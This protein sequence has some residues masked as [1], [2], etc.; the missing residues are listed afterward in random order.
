MIWQCLPEVALKNESNF[1]STWLCATTINNCL[2]TLSFSKSWS[3]SRSADK[4]VGTTQWT[5]ASYSR[6][7]M[8]SSSGWPR[9]FCSAASWARECS[10]WKNSSKLLLSEFLVV[11]KCSSSPLFERVHYFPC[12]DKKGW[13]AKGYYWVKWPNDWKGLFLNISLFAFEVFIS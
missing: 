7:A 6:D 3:T 9:R 13:D 10:W 12:D 11:T 2:N 8:R 1:V 5:W 4:E